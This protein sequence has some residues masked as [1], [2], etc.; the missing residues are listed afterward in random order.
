MI[1]HYKYH[2]K[3]ERDRAPPKPSYSV[4]HKVEWNGTDGLS[5]DGKAMLMATAMVTP[6]VQG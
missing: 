3:A 1:V 6:R 2:A 5:E 4:N